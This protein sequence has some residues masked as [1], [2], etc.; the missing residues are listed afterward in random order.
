MKAMWTEDWPASINRGLRVSNA[1]G[2]VSLR[3]F[4]LHERLAAMLPT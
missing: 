4:L 1:T 2:F 3:L